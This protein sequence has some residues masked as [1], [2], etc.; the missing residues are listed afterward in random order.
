MFHNFKSAKGGLVINST[1]ENKLDLLNKNML[2]AT[3]RLDTIVKTCDTISLFMV[4][5]NKQLDFEGKFGE[6]LDDFVKETS[7]QTDP[8]EQ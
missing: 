1:L 6:N 8:D 7:H 4:R 2:Y 3:H 5:I